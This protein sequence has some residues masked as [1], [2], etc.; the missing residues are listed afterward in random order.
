MIAVVVSLPVVG[1]LLVAGCGGSS[2]ASSSSSAS[3]SSVASGAGSTS[4]S[5]STTSS[6]SGAATAGATR[7]PTAP[8]GASGSA[9]AGSS[10]TRSSTTRT[11]SPDTRARLPATFTIRAGGLLLPGVVSAPKHTAIALLVI[12]Q[13][14]LAHAFVLKAPHVR[15]GRVL[16]GRPVRLLLKGLPDGAYAVQVDGRVRG[17][18]IIG[19]TPGP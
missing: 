6:S 3:S 17:R 9:T 2:P 14:G 16:P 5:G 8:A 19:A 11:P 15:A 12:S 18:L 10:T 7:T 1:S 13:D 4:S